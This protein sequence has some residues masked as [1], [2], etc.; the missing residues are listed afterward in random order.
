MQVGPRKKNIMS[1]F[2]NP[3]ENQIHHGIQSGSLYCSPH[4]DW[5]NT[6]LKQ[7]SCQGFVKRLSGCSA[8]GSV[9]RSLTALESGNGVLAPAPRRRQNFVASSKGARNEEIWGWDL[10]L[11]SSHLESEKHAALRL[12]ELCSRHQ[13]KGF[14]R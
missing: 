3:L 13:S 10:E 7:S 12:S 2:K 8:I 5:Y 14:C 9:S 6:N 11:R 4:L 1:K